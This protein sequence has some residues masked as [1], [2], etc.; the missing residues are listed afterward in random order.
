MCEHCGF[1]CVHTEAFPACQHD[2]QLMARLPLTRGR[3]GTAASYTNRPMC[4]GKAHFADQGLGPG[5]QT[6]ENTGAY[7]RCRVG[8]ETV[9][10]SLHAEM[11]DF[12]M[13]S[14][15]T[16][17]SDVDQKTGQECVAAGSREGYR[18]S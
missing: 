3:V 11:A 7:R 12:C 9:Q 4:T 13:T 14:F 17:V 15:R 2:V 5:K 18:S 8:R 1:V 10:F 6:V 16:V